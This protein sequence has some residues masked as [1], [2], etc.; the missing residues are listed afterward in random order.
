[1][2]TKAIYDVVVQIHPPDGDYPGQV[3]EGKFTHEDGVVTLV[4]H[5]GNP[6]KNYTKKISPDENP[7]VVARRLTRQFYFARRG[8]K[9]LKGFDRPINYPKLPPWM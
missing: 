2:T 4:D 8:G 6:L 5:N 9:N 7:V 1:M 3:C